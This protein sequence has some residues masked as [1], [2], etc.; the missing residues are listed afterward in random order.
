MIYSKENKSLISIIFW[1]SIIFFIDPGGYVSYYFHSYLFGLYYH[2]FW[3]FIA[4]FCFFLK[5]Y[6]NNAFPKLN[7][8]RIYLL[9]II[10]WLSYYFIWYYWLN[11]K[12]Y[13]GFLP[14][15]SR[16]SRM[17]T[18]TFIVFPL[19]YF[20]MISLNSFIKIQ[21]WVTILVISAFVFSIFS[22]IELVPIMHDYRG[23]I[24]TNRHF[25]YGYGLIYFSLSLGI[26]LLFSKFKANR[27]IYL[28]SLL[29]IVLIFLTF[30]RRN[31]IGILEFVVIILFLIN[32]IE[33]KK[34]FFFVRKLF[35][36]R[37][38]T[39]T[40][41][42]ISIIVI[43]IP[44]VVDFIN[45]TIET[46]Y[47]IFETSKTIQG[48]TDARLSLTKNFAI[49]QTIEQNMI[50]GTGYNSDWMTGK[51]GVNKWEG[52][53]YI[54]LSAFAMY[55]LIGLILFIP[56]Y[57]LVISIIVKLLKLLRSNIKI[58]YKFQKT[59]MFPTIVGVAA[60]A[61]F[62]KNIIEYPNWFFPIGA[63]P[64]SIRYFMYFGLLLGSYYYLRL[65]LKAIKNKYYEN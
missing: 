5:F 59:F 11:N 50:S 54:F 58:I 36:L 64:Y 16:N 61:E 42:T 18:Q 55:G 31:I 57:F 62:I 19:V 28:A 4:Y 3:F 27:L 45:T 2:Y 8:L 1:L 24:N 51:G 43:F 34:V 39:L 29:V 25:M 63:T 40:I 38:I 12:Y 17:I 49:V 35:S 7:Y 65:N 37:I 23:F 15:V 53:D 9:I 32:Y 22:G 47:S 52:A 20:T 56:F 60:S 14:M 46:T 33:G 30:L 41:I 13:P 48:K 21:T 6:Q 44:V 10:I 26:A